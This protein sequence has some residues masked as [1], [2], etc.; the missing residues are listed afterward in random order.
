VLY[1]AP[2]GGYRPN[3][4]GLQDMHGNVSELTEDCY[5]DSYAGAPSDGA[6]WTAGDCARRVYR[7]GSWH[8]PPGAVR[9]SNRD[10]GSASTRLD[11]LGF[12]LI[13]DR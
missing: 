3:G 10:R 9:S 12:R 7:G 8:Y 6:A 5:H 11:T 13:Q 4:F 1:T 2:V